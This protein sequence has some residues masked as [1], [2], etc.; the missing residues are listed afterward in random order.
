MFAILWTVAHQASL[1]MGFPRQ[2]YWSELP[3]HSVGELSNP[4]IEPLSPASP[5][6]A[7]GFFTFDSPR[8]PSL[9]DSLLPKSVAFHNL[10]TFAEDR[11]F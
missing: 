4:E 5:A 1:S 10:L 8:K 11:K 2:E 6:L 9:N 3:F 7:S